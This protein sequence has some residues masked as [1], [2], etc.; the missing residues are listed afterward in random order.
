MSPVVRRCAFMLVLGLA[1]CRDGTAPPRPSSL[2]VVAAAPASLQAGAV[3]TAVTIAVLDEK[4][5]AMANQPLAIAVA[6]GG[7]LAGAPARTQRDAT[8]VGAWTLASK[9]GANALTI[10]SGTLPPL[11]ISVQ[12]VAGPPARLLASGVPAS[13]TVGATIP[14]TVMVF[15][16]LDNAVGGAAIQLVPTGGGSLGPGPLVTDAN[17]A[18]A[19]QWTLGTARGVNTLSAFVGTV[20]ATLTAVANPD[21]PAAIHILAGDAQTANAG[22]ALADPIRVTVVDRFG[23]G[24]PG[25]TVT[26]AVE[27]GGGSLNGAQTTITDDNG[28]AAAP[29]WMLGRRNVPQQLAVSVGGIRRL[30]AAAVRSDFSL[31]L[32]FIGTTTDAQKAVFQAAAARVTAAIVRGAGP[33]SAIAF[34]IA[35]ACGLVGMDPLT[36]I[37]DGIVV[38][39]GVGPIDGPGNILARAGPC[40]LRGGASGYLPAIA[41]MLFDQADLATLET[42]AS[43]EDVI[44]HEMFH[45]LGFGT[46]WSRLLLTAGSSADPRYTGLNGRTACPL[47]A[48]VITCGAYVPLENTGGSG[49]AGAHWRESV[50]RNELM[51]GYL[52]VGADP[53]SVM[54]IA[55]MVDLGYEVSMTAADPFSLTAALRAS[56]AD[57]SST[58]PWEEVRA[59]ARLDELQAVG[60]L[61]VPPPRRP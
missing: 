21:V 58:G 56:A 30:V 5:N 44:V 10:V 18:A 7:S 57:V 25:Q 28:G 3:V 39:A 11:T 36:E 26:F 23:N 2:V 55:A 9:V 1:G 49:T 41:T 4:G 46:L 40:A 48:S 61:L 45:S 50:F 27:A 43:L 15:D 14:L 60:G 54:S 52:N 51:T 53:L 29:A 38:Y 22:V 13:A 33:V 8:P 47:I 35:T 31:V 16:A 12:G 17:G 37:I 19:V 42:G 59:P 34:P 32:R 6:G 20:A 24:T